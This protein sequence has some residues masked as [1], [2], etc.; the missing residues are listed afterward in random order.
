MSTTKTGI[1]HEIV[2]AEDMRD[3]EFSAHWERTALARELSLAVVRYRAEHGLSQRALA[4]KLGVRQ[5]QISRLEDGETTPT[6]DTLANVAR[7]LG[8]NVRLEVSASGSI[9][10]EVA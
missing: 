10:A 2:H 7:V 1:P 4:A 6:L 3:P 5:P 8:L 9:A